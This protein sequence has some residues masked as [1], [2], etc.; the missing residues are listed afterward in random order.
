MTFDIKIYRHIAYLA[1]LNLS[2]PFESEGVLA[3]ADDRTVSVHSLH[4]LASLTGA[5]RTRLP[6]GKAPGGPIA[7]CSYRLL[8]TALTYRVY[9]LFIESSCFLSKCW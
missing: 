2:V 6:L 8:A 5:L 1:Y 7:L 9:V 3:G 4:L